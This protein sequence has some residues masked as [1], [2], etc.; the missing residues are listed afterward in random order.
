MTRLLASFENLSSLGALRAMF[1]EPD[2]TRG[3][4]ASVRQGSLEFHYFVA[5]GELQRGEN[6]SHAASHIADVLA[7]EASRAE[8]LS[9]V[10]ELDRASGGLE[11]LLP[12]QD[13]GEL[14]FATEAL[15]ALMWLR[16]A[17]VSEAI[18]LLIQVAQ[19]KPGV[20][21]L[22]AWVLDALEAGA[23][24]LDPELGMRLLATVLMS[25]PENDEMTAMQEGRARRWARW[26]LVFGKSA[27]WDGQ[28]APLADMMIPG[29]CRKAG[30]F[31]EGLTLAN[32]AVRARRSW[33]ALTGQGL[34]LRRS[35]ALDAARASFEE[36]I[37]LE[38]D[39]LAAY[40]E[41]GD[42]F[43]EH[44]SWAEALRYYERVLAIDPDHPWALPSVL[45]CRWR[46]TS[47]DVPYAD[48]A[49]PS[50]FFELARED[51]H[52]A[53]ALYDVF[54]PWVG[55]VPEPHDATTSSIRQML[56]KMPPGSPQAKG[57]VKLTLS[58][59]E[60]PSNTVLLRLLYGDA[61]KL[62]VRYGNIASPDP[63][64]PHAAV[65]FTLWRREGDALAPAL[66]PPSAPVAELVRELASRPFAVT[67]A[68]AAASRA[69]LQ[70]SR[71]DA[72]SLL[73]CVVHPPPMPPG[74]SDGAAFAW[75][76]RVQCTVA[77]IVGQLCPEE[78]W[79]SSVRR[80][81]LL[82]LLHGPLDWSTEVAV[83]AL[84][85]IAHED[86]CALIDIHKAFARLAAARPDAG[87]APWEPSLL[88]YWRWLPGL[89]PDEQK[90][91][92]ERLQA[93]ALQ[94]E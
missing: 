92:G 87:T 33:H 91:L 69:A 2:G 18:D 71:A 76:P 48:E 74:S 9:I 39:N 40:L 88:A 58:D 55:Q 13:A 29:L 90:Q 34:L 27:T 94:G 8:F 57:N 79:E 30:L 73:A 15:R 26:A 46:E 22:D 31:D 93:L 54:R 1:D 20:R 56:E 78:D 19:A 25:F 38:P 3:A 44:Q 66:P 85:R 4:A 43:F 83:V 89:Y 45:F 68:W 11:A 41:A 49:F 72:A 7:A 36:A 37:G 75:I 81:A 12:A 61:L 67:K 42:M 64:E 17:R 21:Y 53:Q 51:N 82:S 86:P 59:V 6:L 28:T 52:R 60:A 35:G 70:L 16:R 32:A 10:D 80:D 24:P 5:R 63:R 77:F 50:R 14:Y 65:A 62:E 47:P 84:S 23:G